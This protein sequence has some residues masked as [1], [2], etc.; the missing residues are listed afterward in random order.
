MCNLRPFGTN[1]VF[2]LIGTWL[3]QGQDIFG[4]V[5]DFEASAQLLPLSRL[6]LNQSTY[7]RKFLMISKFA[8][9]LY[10]V[11]HLATSPKTW[12]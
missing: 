12:P 6:Y 1:W 5:T 11:S 2:K 7:Q 4:T 3:G 9:Q 10:L 8:E